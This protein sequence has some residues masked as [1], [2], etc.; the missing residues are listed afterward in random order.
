MLEPVNAQNLN[1]AS[2]TDFLRS[3]GLLLWN[4]ALIDRVAGTKQ[5]FVDR[6]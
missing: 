4:K 5:S 3:R 1:P 6:Y 2:L